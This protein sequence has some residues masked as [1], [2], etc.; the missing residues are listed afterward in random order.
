[1]IKNRSSTRT[2]LKTLEEYVG[3]LSKTRKQF[4]VLKKIYSD[5][6]SKKLI[7][8]DPNPPKDFIEY[9]GRA[10]YSLW[11]WV[12]AFLAIIIIL[13]IALTPLI[14]WAI[15]IRYVIGSLTVLFLPGY[16]TVEALYPKED[17]LTSLERLALSIGLSLAIVPLIGLILNYTPWGIRLTSVVIALIVY[18]MVIAMVASYRKYLELQKAKG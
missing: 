9:L 1:M 11:L 5:S 3:E 17:E 18:T 14:P 2:R 15:Y 10:D 8:L 7:L 16:V 13:T 4:E 12:V 6:I